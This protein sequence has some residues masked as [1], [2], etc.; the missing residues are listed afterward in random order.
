MSAPLDARMTAACTC[1]VSAFGLRL[2][3][4]VLSGPCLAVWTEQVQAGEP[5]KI[6]AG[7]KGGRPREVYLLP[8]SRAKVL[9]ALSTLQAVAAGQGGSIVAAETAER[10]CWMLSK[11][12]AEQGENVRALRNEFAINQ[13]ASETPKPLLPKSESQ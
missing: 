1:L 12:F 11:H 7:T 8:A 9:E 13:A 6:Y 10:A 5:I 4:L 2:R 3:E